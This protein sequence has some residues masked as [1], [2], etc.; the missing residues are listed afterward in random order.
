M[1]LNSPDSLNW[2]VLNMVDAIQKMQLT[3]DLKYLMVDSINHN[4]NEQVYTSAEKNRSPEKILEQFEEYL[5]DTDSL[6]FIITLLIIKDDY[7]K[8][9]NVISKYPEYFI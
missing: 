6:S 1:G 4:C 5:D 9:K 7:R 8:Y 3:D 2:P